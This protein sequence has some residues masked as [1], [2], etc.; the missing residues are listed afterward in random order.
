MK[1]QKV[2]R[3]VIG[4]LDINSL[5]GKS[6]QLKVVIENN[7]DFLNVTETKIDSSFSSSQFMIEG[8]LMPFRFDRNRSGGGVI[9][10]VQYDIPSKQLSKHKRPDNIE[11]VFIKVN[12]RKTKLLILGT[13]CPPSQP[14]DYFFKNRGYPLDIY[15]QTYEKFFLAGDFNT[16]ETEPCFSEFFTSYDSKSLAKNKT[17]CKNPE[18]VRCIDLFITNSIGSF[19]RKTV[20]ASSLSDSHKMIVTVCKSSFQKSKPKEILYRIYKYFDINTFK[21]VLRL[22]FSLL[23]A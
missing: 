3:L 18:N 13:Y 2:H 10:F 21:N 20:V 16:E 5:P 6:N 1:L 12:L 14:V 22:N 23:R 8:F 9:G 17:Y 15:R 19:H 11:G 7:I 4:H